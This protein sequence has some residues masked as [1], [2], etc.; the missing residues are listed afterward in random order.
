[1][2]YLQY[3]N[4]N[5]K[6]EFLRYYLTSAIKY[7]QKFM[8]VLKL[9]NIWNSTALERKMNYSRKQSV[10]HEFLIKECFTLH[11]PQRGSCI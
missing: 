6:L 1:M 3:Q 4:V 5:V 11:K 8:K 7:W 10:S 2:L 9:Q